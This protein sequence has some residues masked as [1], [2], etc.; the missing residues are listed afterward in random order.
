MAKNAHFWHF[1][2]W[3]KMPKYWLFGV[4]FSYFYMKIEWKVKHQQLIYLLYI[5][6][7]EKHFWGNQ[8]L[9]FLKLRQKFVEFKKFHAIL[10]YITL[11]T[12]SPKN[13]ANSDSSY[14]SIF[15]KKLH[16]QLHFDVLNQKTPL[17]VSIWLALPWEAGYLATAIFWPN[18]LCCTDAKHHILK[19]SKC[20]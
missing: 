3:W 4:H 16:G 6:Y 12:C 18:L 13:H 2:K 8:T 10:H 1:A 19:E 11:S 5:S 7:I 9:F 14:V 17:K 20:C 15:F